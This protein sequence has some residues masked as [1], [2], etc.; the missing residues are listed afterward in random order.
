[1][2]IGVIRYQADKITMDCQVYEINNE[3]LIR[4][5]AKQT[6][7]FT[8]NCGTVGDWI[9]EII[10]QDFTKILFVTYYTY[11]YS[12]NYC[13]PYTKWYVCLL[14]TSRCV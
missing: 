10:Q 11:K 2:L 4:M 9:K 12:L 1:M 6:L 5:P 7:Q 13:T 3:R 14:Y 8:Y